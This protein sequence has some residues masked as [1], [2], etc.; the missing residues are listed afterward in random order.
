MR[1]AKCRKYHQR[2]RGH[3]SQPPDHLETAH[4]RQP[5]VNQRNINFHVCKAFQ[6]SLAIRKLLDDETFGFKGCR[7]YSPDVAV[8]FDEEHTRF[9]RD[10]LS[11]TKI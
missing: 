8:V 1:V 11:H 10:I 7:N 9:H 4:A 2:N 6:R 5:Q 3:W